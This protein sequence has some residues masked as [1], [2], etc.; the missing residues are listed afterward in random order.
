MSDLLQALDWDELVGRLGSAE[1]LEASARKAGALLRK[2]Q[3]G[4]AVDLLRLCF[5]YVLGRFSL[6]DLGGLGR[7]AGARVD[8]RRSDA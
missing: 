8:V 6:S 5:A 2:R 7:S 4:G 1:E 3:V